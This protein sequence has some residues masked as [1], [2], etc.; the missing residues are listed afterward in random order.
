MTTTRKAFS[1][2][3]AWDERHHKRENGE[4]VLPADRWMPFEAAALCSSC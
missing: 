3:G 1:E 4:N 2:V